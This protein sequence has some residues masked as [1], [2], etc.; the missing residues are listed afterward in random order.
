MIKRGKDSN[1]AVFCFSD[2]MWQMPLL[3]LV[4]SIL[5]W[6]MFYFFHK[7]GFEKLA[8]STRQ[9]TRKDLA[10]TQ[11]GNGTRSGCGVAVIVR[12]GQ[13]EPTHV[14]AQRWRA[15]HNTCYEH[16]QSTRTSTTAAGWP[17]TAC[18]AG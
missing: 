1:E 18:G 4:C 15:S 8:V 13:H 3:V 14:R 2:W 6:V 17:N 5:E 16:T 12:R 10:P 7:F 11:A 9:H